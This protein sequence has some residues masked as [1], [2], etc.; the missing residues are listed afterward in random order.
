LTSSIPYGFYGHVRVVFVEQ[1]GNLPAAP[2]GRVAVL[3]VAFAG[4]GM[5]KLA[6]SFAPLERLG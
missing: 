5:K 1:P 2:E 4:V 3:D 6:L